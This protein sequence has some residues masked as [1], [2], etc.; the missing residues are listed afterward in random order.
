MESSTGK[1]DDFFRK[2]IEKRRTLIDAL[3]ANKGEV[4]LDIFEDFYPDKAH[5]VYELLQNAEDAGAI[6][7]AFTL[8]A[9][10]LICEHDG[11]RKFTEADVSA[12]T[13]IHNSTKSQD[14]D[15][16]K[17][18][19]F[20][21][22]FKSVFVY[23]QS[24]TVR[25]GDFSFRIVKLILPEEIM[26][27]TSLGERTRFEFPF[28]NPKKLPT[29]AFEEIA[30]GFRDLDETTL[31]F[32]SNLQAIR[33]TIEAGSAGEVLR[34]EHSE[35]HFEVLKQEGQ[36][37]T[38]SSHFL[39]FDM[40][41]P[42]LDKQRV[43]VAFPLDF[44]AGVR[45]FDV[46][47]S[48]AEQMKIVPATP[49]RVAVFFTAAKESSGL[50]FH[51]HG[52]F[53]PE[54]SR[55]SLKE[56]PANDPLFN[57]LAVLAAQSLHRIRD[58]DL[59]TPDFLAV[60]PVQQ[61]Q[62]PPRYQSIRSA[63]VEE[64]KSS[65]LTPT[66]RRGHAKAD[67]LIQAKASL[68][69]LLSD[70]DIE[71]LVD[72]DDEAPL[73]AI[74]ATQKN[75][76]I[77]SFLDGLDLR[78]WA[79]DE[80]IEV[81]K[82]NA[83]TVQCYVNR[84]PY[85][86]KEP[87]QKFIEWL[88]G[89]SV[90]WMQQLY[91]LLHD[92]LVESGSASKLKNLKIVRLHDG[93]LGVASQVYFPADTSR[94]RGLPTVD[95]AIY[96]SGKSKMQ[97]GKAKRF[98]L[99]LGVR[100]VGEAEEVEIILNTRY[101]KEAAVPDDK[102]YLDDLQRFVI[103]TEEQPD[104][105]SLFKDFYIFQ[106]RDSDWCTPESIYLDGPYKET[107]LS[108]YFGAL[109]EDASC[110]ALHERYNDCGITPERL[111]KF[112]EAV[113]ATARLL[114]LRT[115]CSQNPEWIYLRAAPGERDTSPM[116]KDYYVPHLRKLLQSPNVAL[117]RL[118]WRTVVAL[119]KFSE[120]Y[121]AMF[122]HNV[123]SGA[124]YADSCLVH[125][126]RSESWVPQIDGSFV[127]PQNALR[128]MLPDGFPFDLAYAGLKA[129][130]FGDA[131]VQA[132]AEIREKDDV[133]KAAGFAD[134]EALN[135]AQRFAALPAEEQELILL[136]HIKAVQLTAVPDR[137]PANPAR[138]AQNITKQAMEAPD[139]ESEI[140]SRS[141]SIGREDVKEEAAEY[142]RRHYRN[143]QGEMTCQICKG[144]LPFKLDDG[145]DF[146]ER[147]EFLPELRKRHSQNYLALCPN[148]AAMYRHANASK[149]E[150]RERFQELT[151][152]EMEIVLG[153]KELTIYFSKIHVIDM[154]AVLVAEG[155]QRT[156]GSIRGMESGEHFGEESA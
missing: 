116:N 140:R 41:V 60:L 143:P 78:D 89:K 35:F 76:R 24:P 81:L 48:L 90:E 105:K 106:R 85:I 129:I 32:L 139:K 28:D 118:V 132:S 37:T 111:G 152:N 107:D 127:A 121:Q 26:H 154:K 53:V 100:E 133:A 138:R 45:Q 123:S 113:G 11:Q 131:A 36:K 16:D 64:M 73:W 146:F 69:E 17:I 151:G 33:W 29:E 79:I 54:L 5:F 25:S 120:Y 57:Q 50:F 30:T 39:K 14:K 4:N 77:D 136:K 65:T 103:L 75:S 2:L 93:A 46:K 110:E 80:F 68:K 70:D 22:G 43:A 1:D 21:V 137:D 74:G 49:G 47:K 96:T 101:T 124:H 38:S 134:S 72:Y 31:L 12:I 19:K 34:H 9:D 126:L 92:E 23:T 150:V 94:D 156:S 27:D 61:D 149:E 6:E 20:G 91:A 145:S 88:G 62:I 104:K 95:V 55:A 109:G 66:H 83:S 148:H 97:Q 99:E 8:S 98:L 42:E 86:V 117:S 115:K 67:R 18:G 87:D 7:V 141:V 15:S 114:I 108:A 84:P 112:A 82:L 130:K 63:I 3:D 58:I 52:P 119:P 40:P 71:Y 102:T 144:P 128:E 147:V 59:L 153:Q 51:L 13:G 44:L 125:D 122:R 10:R 135:R 56:T 142:L 155:G